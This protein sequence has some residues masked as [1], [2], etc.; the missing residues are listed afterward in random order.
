MSTLLS[1]IEVKAQPNCKIGG[2]NLITAVEVTR[3]PADSRDHCWIREIVMF[4]TKDLKKEREDNIKKTTND[5]SD[6][7]RSSENEVERVKKK[8]QKDFPGTRVPDTKLT[9]VTCVSTRVPIL[10]QGDDYYH[11]SNGGTDN[12]WK[13]VKTPSLGETVIPIKGYVNHL[14]NKFFVASQNDVL[15]GKIHSWRCSVLR[16]LKDLVKHFERPNKAVED[17]M[18][19]ARDDV[20][21]I[22]KGID[23]FNEVMCVNMMSLKAIMT[24]IEGVL[25]CEHAHFVHEMANCDKFEIAVITH[26]YEYNLS[27][28]TI[29]NDKEEDKFAYGKD[30]I[31]DLHYLHHEKECREYEEKRKREEEETK[32]NQA[33]SEEFVLH[34][35]TEKPLVNDEKLDLKVEVIG[36]PEIEDIDV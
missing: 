34:V 10:S 1:S 17:Q 11:I 27:L 33:P 8:A 31:D 36:V 14:N 5:S 18:S 30:R 2:D 23:K 26:D 7:K 16:Y 21:E 13:V 24:Y 19:F 35:K 6:K 29:Y 20:F 15:K 3:A 9:N 25:D 22:L 12:V 4:K 28:V 32:L